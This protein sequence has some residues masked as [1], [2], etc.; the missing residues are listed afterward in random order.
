MTTWPEHDV[1]SISPGEHGRRLSKTEQN[2]AAHWLAL[3]RTAGLGASRG[4]R[5]LERIGSPRAILDAGPA[6]WRREGL[7]AAVREALS[8]PDWAAVEDDLHW[9][10]QPNHHLITRDDP[11]YPARLR[12]IARPPLALVV[13]GDPDWRARPRWAVVGR[14]SPTRG[15]R[16]PAREFAAFMARSGLVITS[17]LALGIDGEAHQAALASGGTSV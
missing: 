12:E 4:A 5:L 17:G 2:T 6:R 3:V 9:L 1:I 7:P 15:G 10:E 16:E 14:R 8:R 13:R 11:R